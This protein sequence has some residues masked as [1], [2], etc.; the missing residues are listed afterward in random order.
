[1]IARIFFSNS[2]LLFIK[3]LLLKLLINE[4]M[5]QSQY[6]PQIEF[7]EL[8]NLKNK[9]TKKHVIDQFLQLHMHFGQ[10]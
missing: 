2:I 7:C 9:Q 4:L 10:F 8:Y 3:E 6:Q 5:Q 1:M